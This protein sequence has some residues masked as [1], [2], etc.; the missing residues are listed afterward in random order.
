MFDLN[1]EL[2]QAAAQTIQ[3]HYQ[4]EIDPS[5]LNIQETKKNFEG[6]F[7][8]VVFPLS[9]Y[10]LGAP[11]QV[12]ETLG[13]LL[14]ERLDYIEQYNVVKGF[15]NLSLTEGFWRRFLDE[16][17]EDKAFFQ[18]Q[19]GDGQSVVVEY[20][21]PNTNKPLHLGHLRNIVLGYSLTEILKANGYTVHPVCLY[22]DR[23]TAICKSMYAWQLSGKD[24]SPE[25]TGKK[26]DLLVG[27]YYVAFAQLL[28]KQV[29]ELTEQ[30][31]TEEEAKKAAPA[32]QAINEM[33]I[34]WEN[35]D[36]EVR[37]LW[38]KMNKWVYDAHMD[39]FKRLGVS[40]EKFYYES[41]LYLRGKDIV[42]EGLEKGIF[43]KNEDGS[44]WVDLEDVKLD[45][46]LLLRAN[47]TSIYITQDLATAEIKFNDFEVQK[48]VYVVGNEQDHHFKVLFEILRRLERPYAEG[49]YHLSYAFVELPHGRM[50]SREGTVVETDDLI[51]EVRTTV[52]EVT[53]ASEKVQGLAGE[54]LD[55]LF[56]NLAL[57]AIKFFL[58]KVD[59]RKSMVFD[60]E[61]S[62]Q[63]QGH[64]GPYI[65]YAHARTQNLGERARGLELP[66]FSASA[67][68]EE[69][70]Q[71]A[72][73]QLLRKLYRYREVL[74]EAGR[75]YNPA[76]IANYAYEL[77]QDF[78]S[79]Y[80]QCRVVQADKPQ[81]SSQR[82]RIALFTGAVIK[83]ALR[84]LGITAP[85]R[86]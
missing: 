7:T 17:A 13:K 16:S 80:D 20:C 44:V 51:D 76:A 54:E 73:R 59:P 32:N 31:M 3:D 10:K 9:R 61:E 79:F 23:G 62:V 41:D 1:Q 82:L 30:G 47:G 81:T 18:L 57:G 70:L 58:V 34:Q 42:N 64:T 53:K 36:P 60:P 29:A 67:D 74:A 6:D 85:D 15:L 8:L 26:G 84:L 46:K 77:A 43:Y 78:S 72:E 38:R 2:A 55:A 50:K 35:E 22:N 83:E 19:A 68:F 12:A 5:V 25:S 27:D 75:N 63:L 39:T 4:V 66:D 52:E 24:E 49:L 65:Q 21:S 71:A 40:F 37:A 48:S 14:C 69:P 28:K 45:K 56:D 86:M 33:L 11:P